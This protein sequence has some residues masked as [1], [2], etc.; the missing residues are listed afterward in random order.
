MSIK[1]I[2]EQKRKTLSPRVFFVE[3]SDNP[4]PLGS[5]SPAL[6]A[7]GILKL[8]E[9]HPASLNLCVVS[10]RSE[11]KEWGLCGYSGWFARVEV[12]YGP[13]AYEI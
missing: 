10:R 3:F 9:L 11:W 6:D 4:W 13:W 2:R 1:S 12:E 5:G 7:E 8:Y